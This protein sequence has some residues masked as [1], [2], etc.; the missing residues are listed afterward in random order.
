MA[1]S[2]VEDQMVALPTSDDG[3]LGVADDAVCN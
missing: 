1:P 3:I 2:E